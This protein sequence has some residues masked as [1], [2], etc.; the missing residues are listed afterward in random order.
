MDF[1]KGV[2]ELRDVWKQANCPPESKGQRHRVIC[3]D[4][5]GGSTNE[6]FQNAFLRVRLWN[7]PPHD[8]DC[9]LDRAALLTQEGS[10]AGLDTSQF[11]RLTRIP[12]STDLVKT[13]L[14]S[15]GH[16]PSLE[17]PS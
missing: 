15:S 9:C 7:R 16:R 3:D 8:L 10:S 17:I 11:L 2:N 1:A 4:A 12:G 6:I 5:R 13:S 14:D